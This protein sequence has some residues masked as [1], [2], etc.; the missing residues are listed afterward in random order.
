MH[1]DDNKPGASATKFARSMEMSRQCVKLNKRILVHME[2]SSWHTAMECSGV[3]VTFLCMTISANGIP[4]AWVRHACQLN[5][6]EIELDYLV[7][8]CLTAWEVAALQ[9]SSRL[10]WQSLMVRS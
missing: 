3:L 6:S 8:T 7:K 2:S 1:E 5:R 10:L 9:P 4:E